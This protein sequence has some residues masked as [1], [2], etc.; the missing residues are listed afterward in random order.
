DGCTGPS[1]GAG[2]ADGSRQDDGRPAACRRLGRG[3]ARHRPRPRGR[4]G[5]QRVGHLRRLRRGVLPGSRA[6]DRAGRAGIARRRARAGRRSGP[7]PPDPRRPR[8]PS[9]GVPAGRARGRCQARGTGPRTSPAAGQRA[10]TDQDASRRASAGLPR[11]RRR[12]RGH[13]RQGPRA[14]GRRGAPR[15]LGVPDRPG[16]GGQ[17][18][19]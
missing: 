17:R 7:R 13:G 6:R 8:G 1:G 3:A 16:G 5:A 4:R 18:W 19:L 2:R 14:G 10:L 12:R 9:G 15:G 11:G